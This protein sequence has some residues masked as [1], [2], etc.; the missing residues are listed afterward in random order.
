MATAVVALFKLH[1]EAVHKKLDELA[2]TEKAQGKIE[3]CIKDKTFLNNHTLLSWY[4]CFVRLF[5]RGDCA[6][7]CSERPTHIP[8]WKW[9]KC[10]L[11]R[12]DTDHWRTDVEFI[13]SLYN[14]F[15][16]RDQINA[17][18]LYF[19]RQQHAEINIGNSALS[20]GKLDAMAK[21]TTDGLVAHALS[22]GEVN[23]EGGTSREEFR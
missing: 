10:L 8:S 15:L 16:R 11:T 4:L 5:P 21:L 3:V 17:V 20:K 9:A 6:E 18:E 13:A 1:N 2:A 22:S 23:S 14:I 7:R 19:K 12:A